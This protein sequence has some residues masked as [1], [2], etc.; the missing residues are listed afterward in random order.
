MTVG[1]RIGLGFGIAMVFAVVIAGLG[2]I[3]IQGVVNDAEEV[4]VGN[5]LDA[6]MAKLE[7]AHLTWANHVGEL[8]TNEEVTTLD[9][10]TDPSKCS[11][12]TW[13]RSS[14]RDDA[15]SQ[16]PSLD[17]LLR[18]L[19]DH[20]AT[21]HETAVEIERSFEQA[22][23]EL[24]GVLALRE[25]DHL[26]WASRVKDL[27]LENLPELDI[28]TD[29]TRCALG[30]WL[31]SSGLR[32]LTARDPDLAE[33]VDAVH[34]PHERLHA[35]A[36]EIQRLW[37]PIHPGLLTT[38]KD[39]LDD[40]RRWTGKVSRACVLQSPDLDV[41]TDP[42]K[43]ELGRF[44]ASPQYAEWCVGFPELKRS[45]EACRDP[46]EKLHASAVAIGQAFRDGNVEAAHTT[47]VEETAPA[48]DAI[49]AHFGDALAA[50]QALVDSQEA[51]FR[52]FDTQTMAAL[53][54]TREA[55]D[56]C[57]LRADDALAG[58]A[59]ANLVFSTQTKPAL[60]TVQDLLDRSREEIRTHV[61]TD[62]TMLGHARTT[63]TF[64][65]I[66]S[67]VALLVASAVAFFLSRQ[68]VRILSG[69]VIGMREGADQVSGAAGQVSSTSQS[70]AEGASEQAASLAEASS[71]L[72]QAA[73]MT[74]QNAGSARE[75][76]EL[77]MQARGNA[78]VGTKT[79][80]QLDTAMNAIDES[81]HEI[82]KIIKVIEEIAS[83]TNLLAL[84]AAVEAARAGEHG[85]GFAVVAEEVRNL[86]VRAA[87]AAGETTVLIEGSVQRAKQGNE[88]VSEAGETLRSIVTDI[89]N[90]SGLLQGID[91][92]SAE[93]S[94]GVQQVNTAVSQMDSV[95][96]A[97]AAGAEES[98]SA[99]EELSAQSYALK[100][101]V[102]QLSSFVGISA[103][104]REVPAPVAAGGV[105]EEPHDDSSDSETW[106]MDF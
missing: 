106:G 75:A 18:E 38:L 61:M 81:S 72:E 43:C 92:A 70:Q 21:L 6:E 35:S 39:R 34:S 42:T 5:A 12:G 104:R 85:K 62:E 40:H 86:A 94:Q 68:I 55:L 95:T 59:E 60:A 32:E 8:L 44:L 13:L 90:V 84:N 102:D 74:R 76:S 29:S 36:V 23:P 89:E 20:H 33:K 91:S 3:G 66:A 93:Q 63:E 17:P 79:M 78:T 73:S 28:Q 46:H 57:R 27:F 105:S 71:A 69:I 10:E 67:V 31:R 77:A 50:E 99:A 58:M 47:Y 7:V 16:I 37:R 101:M 49:A 24:P 83:Q 41:Q 80:E 45:M 4:I 64:I 25:V 19:E 22:D 97:N 100:A 52:V 14:D 87:E 51:A 96:Q 103:Q 1:K 30:K 2:F 56:A 26:V 98:A 9:V 65:A 15:V 88:V 11:L 82:G 48:L 53:A 54:S